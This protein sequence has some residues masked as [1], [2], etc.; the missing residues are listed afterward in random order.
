MTRARGQLDWVLFIMAVALTS[1]GL[2]M[3][4]S[5]SSVVSEMRYHV[6][7]YHFLMRQ[8]VAA[9]IGF[10]LLTAISQTDYRRLA[11][12]AWAFPG[13]GLSIV[14]LLAV[15][16]LDH[17]RHRWISLG[18]M[19]LQ[20][21]EFAKPALVIFLAWF[22]TQRSSVINSRHTLLPA[23]L[24]LLVLAIVVGMAD[25]GTALVLVATAAAVFYVAETDK[26]YLTMAVIATLL[27]GAGA[28]LSKPYRINRILSRLDPNYK[29][30]SIVDPQKKLLAYA[31][32]GSSVRDTNYQGMQ[33]RI[34]VS[35][36]HITGQGLMR[37]RQK[38]L[39]LPEVHTDFIYAVIGEELGLIGAIGILT[40]FV[41]ILWRGFRLYWTALD[42]FGRYLAVGATTC[43]VFQALMNVSVALDMG[44]TKGIPL[45]LVSYG[46]SS[47]LSSLILLGIILSVSERAGADEE[48]A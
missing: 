6:G 48:A 18:V 27:L 29:V 20:P 13:V 7:N 23:S 39:F 41:V 31:R 14:A 30:M 4:F 17:V 16:Q 40:S 28:V 2:V 5:A 35:T 38:L 8:A 43:L 42:D 32:S 36:G 33:S 46:G 10:V 15:Y 44:P 21:S 22:V 9:A 47:L 37:S 12:P 45:P 24:L 1:F 19:Q 34:A 3:V 26:K 25:M 11:S